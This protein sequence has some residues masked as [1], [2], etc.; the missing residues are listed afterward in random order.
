MK[1]LYKV[2]YE[3]DF[4]TFEL[5]LS[6]R[7]SFPTAVTL[8]LTIKPI[9]Q[10]K[11]YDL[12]YLPTNKMI[13]LISKIKS[14]ANHI[15]KDFDKIPGVARK[16]FIEELIT[17][18]LYST[19]ELEGVKS[20]R[21]E[22]A[23]SLRDVESG[24]K[25]TRFFSLIRSYMSLFNEGEDSLPK[26]AGDIREI[27]DLIT[28]EEIDQADLPDGDLFRKESVYVYK[29]SGSGKIIHRGI[30]PEEKII[31]SLEGLLSFLNR[32]EKVPA[33]IRVAIGHYYF[34]YIHPFY[35]GNGRS[36]RFLSSLYLSKEIGKVSATALSRACYNFSKQYYKAF[37]ITNSV[38]NGGELNHFIEM[39]LFIMD[40]TLQELHSQLKEKVYLLDLAMEKIK[41]EAILQDKDR[42]HSRLMF[43]LAQNYFF[44]QAKGLTVQEL[45]PILGLSEST[46]RKIAK[47]LLGLSLINQKGQRP[48]H[49]FIEESYFE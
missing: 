42:N 29:Q 34:G 20:S 37:E 27:Y 4:K 49:F 39:F 32:E 17:D 13:H 28:K 30:L 6:R 12:Y 41:K 16:A 5:E 7:K 47:Q 1:D 36:S 10:D 9:R 14:H 31:S 45:A 3:Q 15:Q 25:K 35:D 24:K 33:L 22:I 46:T 26:E 40:Q 43:I 38:T 48:A 2:F 44:A 8:D 19:N 23:K 18:E 21:K 11:N